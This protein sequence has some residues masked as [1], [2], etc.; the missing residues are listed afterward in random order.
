MPAYPPGTEPPGTEPPGTHAPDTE[1]RNPWA[2]PGGGEPRDSPPAQH[3]ARRWRLRLGIAVGVAVA[4][5]GAAVAASYLRADPAE[6]P[7]GYKV[8]RSAG[9]GFQVA[10]PDDWQLSTSETGTVAGTVFRPESGRDSLLQ[11]LPVTGGPDN[12]CEVL[13]D[14]TKELSAREGYRRISLESKNTTGCELVYEIPNGD[15]G[16]AYAIGRL[17][18]ASDGS[19]WVLMGFGPAA[20]TK[21][22]RARMAAALGSFR[23]G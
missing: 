10:V 5:G 1:P 15:S 14:G 17:A 3:T 8:L 20:D 6:L 13:V 4:L 11:V 12:P 18:V 9:A 19:R 21:A 2:A 7:D 23:P 22:V 16:T